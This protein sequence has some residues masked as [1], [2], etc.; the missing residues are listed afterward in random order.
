MNIDL[1]ANSGCCIAFE[2]KE[3]VDMLLCLT[4]TGNIANF[5]S[6]QR[7]RQPILALST[8][9]QVVRQLN[10]KRG[11]VGYKIPEHLRNKREE[12]ITF[13]LAVAQEQLICN[14]PTSKVI[15]YT[16][17][18]EK[19]PQKEAVTFKVVGGKSPDEDEEQEEEQE[20]QDDH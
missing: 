2:P 9:G 19:D 6:K 12:L 7:P 18:Q 11:V 4:E 3:N 13:I 15:I 5:L 16:A 10:M 14:L 20:D 1:L 17:L 8:S